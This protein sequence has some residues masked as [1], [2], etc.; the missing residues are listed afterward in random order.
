MITAQLADG[1]QL[2]FPDGTNPQVIQTTVKRT[3]QERAAAAPQ[4]GGTL[5][6]FAPTTP[7]PQAQP[8]PELAASPQQPEIGGF[9]AFGRGLT[10][11]GKNTV[12][13]VLQGVADVVE[14]T[15]GRGGEFRELLAEAQQ[16][17]Q[18]ATQ[19]QVGDSTAA[20]VGEF[21]GEA[22][23]FIAALP[24]GGPTLAGQAIAGG[25]GGAIAGAAAPTQQVVPAEEALQQRG[26]G[27]LT[28]GTLGGALGAA[29]RPVTQAIG[30]A[31]RGVARAVKGRNADQVIASR[32]QPGQAQEFQRNLIEAGD[33]SIAIFP[34]IA[35]DEIK[36]F[37]R[38]VA[39]IPGGA[40]NIV[41][42][43]L[44]NRSEDAVRRISKILAR[45]VSGVD[46][47]FGALDDAVKGRSS[48]ASPIYKEAFEETPVIN[49]D[50]IN[51]LL[52]DQRII[53]ALD[54]AKS[55]FG[56]PTETNANSLVALD[57]VKKVLDDIKI[58]A[59]Q[60]GQPQKAAAFGALKKQLV[61]ELDAASPT[62]KQA[63]KIFSDHS[64]VIEAQELGKEFSKF[65]PEQLRR[66]VKDFEPS[67]KEAFKIG[68][69]ENLQNVVNKTS[70]QADPGKRIFGNTQ[71][72]EQLK[73]VFGNEKEFEMFAKKMREEIAG[74]KTKLSVLGNS[75]TDFNQFDEG[76]FIDNAVEA[77]NRGTVAVT[78]QLIGAIKNSVKN[79]YIGLNERNAKKIAETL[80]D[81]QA[82]IDALGRIAARERD[83]GQLLLINNAIKDFGTRGSVIGPSVEVGIRED[84]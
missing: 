68:V 38:A 2:Q 22:A 12:T 78:A 73:A 41:H 54:T 46:T 10:Q 14:A 28:G 21:V 8:T 3:I 9:E 24:A 76:Q 27:A 26:V 6:S 5:S 59:N 29:A 33:E 18:Q 35:G 83:K 44:E 56:V 40:R 63:R 48:A 58:S 61:E 79:R 19:A 7:Q 55:T 17:S 4:G 77:V 69:R 37:T 51:K 81:R 84:N 31:G 65:T 30:A 25:I 50:K 75:R 45:E 82:S 32:L 72:R 16:R 43:A 11:G 15:T 71:K 74:A 39:R 42:E 36:G 53:D 70:D 49:R 23:P 60:S 64:S 57:G 52:Q 20:Q 67:Q 47:Y 13:G 62:Y 34:D 1:T 80:V 66:V